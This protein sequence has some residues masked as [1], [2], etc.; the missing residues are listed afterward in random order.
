MPLV[1]I[2]RFVMIDSPRVILLLS[3]S[4][5]NCTTMDDYNLVIARI[6]HQL[7]L[8]PAVKLNCYSLHALLDHAIVARTE[9]GDTCVQLINDT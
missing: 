9:L 2:A 5:V 8:R 6:I 3:C 1:S 4:K 7:E